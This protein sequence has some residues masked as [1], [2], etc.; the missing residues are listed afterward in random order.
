MENAFLILV[1]LGVAAIAIL[2]AIYSWKQEQKRRE[3]LMAF[4]HARGW[5]FDPSKDASHDNQ[6]AHFEVFRK[7]HSRRAFNTMTGSVRVDGRECPVKAGDFLYKITRSNGKST[8]TSTYRFSYLILHLPFPRV[9]DLLIR[10]ENFMDKLA[11]VVGFDDIDFESEEFSRGFHVASKDKRFAYDV[12]TPAMM[13]F[14]LASRGPTLDI[15]H[16]AFCLTDG[17]RRW[18]PSQFEAWL[19]WGARFIDLWPDH[20]TDSLEAHAR[21]A[22]GD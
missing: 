22:R 15:E 18:E 20:V 3:A 10:P 19:T 6:Y 9:P 13:E 8:S 16:G 14:L 17:V 1:L 12:I 5:S 7:G 2:A 4:A 11:G 21:T